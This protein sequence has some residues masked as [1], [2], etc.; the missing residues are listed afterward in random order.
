MCA[1][2][3]RA[4]PIGTR[5]NRPITALLDR[6]MIINIWIYRLV[7]YSNKIKYFEPPFIHSHKK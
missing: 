1:D 3:I 7:A 6:R 5:D 2:G 4:L